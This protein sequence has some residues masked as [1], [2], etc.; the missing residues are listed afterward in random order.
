MLPE[1]TH[2]Y[3][4]VS[5]IT[6]IFATRIF[7]NSK[8]KNFPDKVFFFPLYIWNFLPKLEFLQLEGEKIFPIKFFPL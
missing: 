6:G 3:S 7:Y 8:E 2:I 5:S 1:K 4:N